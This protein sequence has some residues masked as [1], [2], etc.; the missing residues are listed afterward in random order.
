MQ[1]IAVGVKRGLAL[2]M[3]CVYPAYN[4]TFPNLKEKAQISFIKQGRIPT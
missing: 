3:F 2:K 1:H 4:N